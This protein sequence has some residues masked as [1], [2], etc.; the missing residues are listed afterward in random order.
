MVSDGM[1]S[2]TLEMP[3]EREAAGIRKDRQQ[4]PGNGDDAKRPV[5]KPNRKTY[6]KKPPVPAYALVIGRDY[7]VLG[8]HTSVKDAE[9]TGHEIIGRLVL[10][11]FQ[12]GKQPY[13]F[14]EYSVRT[15]GWIRESGTGE[16]IP[17]TPDVTREMGKKH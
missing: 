13:K 5:Q 11:C 15:G 10:Y 12:Q 14:S 4:V 8:T 6:G 9:Y 3:G 17:A 7:D 2:S 1:H 16:D